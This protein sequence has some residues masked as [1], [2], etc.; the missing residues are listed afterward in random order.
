[1]STYS[2]TH[3]EG[4][5]SIV[6]HHR[7]I[8]HTRKHLLG[9][10]SISESM[11]RYLGCSLRFRWV[12]KPLSF[13]I[14][15]SSVLCVAHNLFGFSPMFVFAFPCEYWHGK[16]NSWS[17]LGDIPDRWLAW[18]FSAPHRSFQRELRLMSWSMWW[19]YAPTHSVDHYWSRRCFSPF[20]LSSSWF[21]SRS[22]AV[23][24][25]SWRL[26]YDLVHCRIKKV[27]YKHWLILC[28]QTV[29]PQRKTTHPAE[30][31]SSDQEP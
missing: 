16:S 13:V 22:R 7:L 5:D 27:W 14:V 23:Y 25:R 10:K 8:A 26:W 6:Q 29:R 31:L 28:R 18:L 15:Y 17:L 4:R 12:P 21:H 3:G 19:C 30:L 1:M 24:S 2:R 9:T 20:R 11:K